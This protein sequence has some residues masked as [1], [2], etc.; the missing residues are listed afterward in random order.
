MFYSVWPCLCQLLLI[1]GGF[2]KE[3]QSPTGNYIGSSFFP[4]LEI[5]LRTTWNMT[6]AVAC[7]LPSFTPKA[8]VEPLT[9]ALLE[10]CM[11]GGKCNGRMPWA[12]FSPDT[13]LT[14]YF[15]KGIEEMTPLSLYIPS[16]CWSKHSSDTRS[17]LGGQKSVSAT[18]WQWVGLSTAHSVSSWKKMANHICFC[19][20]TKKKSTVTC[21]RCIQH[22]SFRKSVPFTSLFLLIWEIILC[23]NPQVCL[24]LK[25][26]LMDLPKLFG[27]RA[28][29]KYENKN[30]EPHLLPLPIFGLARGLRG[31]CGFLTQLCLVWGHLSFFPIPSLLLSVTPRAK[32]PLQCK[33]IWNRICFLFSYTGAILEQWQEIHP[34]TC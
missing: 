16:G 19:F 31:S 9:E 2:T 1:N 33:E 8:G 5:H 27:G 26:N 13:L 18:A 30:T 12:W 28:V 14:P 34:Y 3:P 21:K 23:G 25:Q 4:H 6:A 20:F 22:P 15:N 11:G 7:L 29:Y 24:Y 32:E 17:Y 10:S